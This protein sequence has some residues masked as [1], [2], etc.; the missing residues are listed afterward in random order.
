MH[1]G[2]ELDVQMRREPVRRLQ[3]EI[4]IHPYIYTV[5]QTNSQTR[6][7]IARHTF[8][9]LSDRHTY[10]YTVR[11]TYTQIHSQIGIHTYKYTVRQKNSHTCKYI[12]RH[13]DSPP[14]RQTVAT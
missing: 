7:C 9:T 11:N 14:V 12:A 3:T 5:R 13:T 6:K 10:R 8:D 4:Q 2:R 1:Q